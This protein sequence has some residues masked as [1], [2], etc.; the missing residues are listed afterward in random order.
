[1]GK[2]Y[3]SI[4]DSWTSGWTGTNRSARY[5][6]ASSLNKN[7][8]LH[9]HHMVV[10]HFVQRIYLMYITKHISNKNVTFSLRNCISPTTLNV[11]VYRI[12]YSRTG[13][14]KK[15]V[16]FIAAILWIKYGFEF[17]FSFRMLLTY[18]AS[19]SYFF[20][21]NWLEKKYYNI[22]TFRFVA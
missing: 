3:F 15:N 2:T 22:S 20:P 21:H 10:K 7:D 12:S 6:A 14:A 8:V 17:Q 18:R 4:Q 9:I 11:K 1:M 13:D 19:I 16:D 5:L